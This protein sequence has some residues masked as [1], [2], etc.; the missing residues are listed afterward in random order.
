MKISKDN[1]GWLFTCVG[2]L[3]LLAL[4]VYLGVSGFF[5]KTGD[6]YSSDLILGQTVENG[7]KKNQASSYSLN[8][9]GGYLPNE[10]LSQIVSIKNLEESGSLYIRAKVFICSAQNQINEID[11]IE[12]SHWTKK[13]DGYFYYDSLLLPQEKS[14]FSTFIIAP[15]EE[16]LASSWKKYVLT[17]VFESLDGNCDVESLWGYNPIQNN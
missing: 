14:I 17:F 5:F 7:I 4:S 3:I 16:F 6:S 10:R 9:P 8:M 12:N 2:L 15:G 11:V 1:F 13:D